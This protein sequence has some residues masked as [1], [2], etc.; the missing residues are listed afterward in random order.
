MLFFENADFYYI[1]T[2]EKLLII[3]LEIYYTYLFLLYNKKRCSFDIIKFCEIGEFLKKI[4]H[5]LY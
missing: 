2:I 1:C 3:N 4:F 5:F